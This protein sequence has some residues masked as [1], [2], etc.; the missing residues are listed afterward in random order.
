MHSSLV[1]K[2]GNQ[3]QEWP[4]IFGGEEVH[5]FGYLVGETEEILCVQRQV[6]LIS[7]AVWNKSKSPIFAS[8]TI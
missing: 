8:E 5:A 7:I 4:H 3:R 1:S 6:I 2:A